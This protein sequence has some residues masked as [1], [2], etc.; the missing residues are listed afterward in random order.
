MHLLG[1]LYLMPQVTELLHNVITPV[2]YFR[3]VRELVQPGTLHGVSLILF[4]CCTLSNMYHAV[5]D[6]TYEVV[7]CSLYNACSSA[8]EAFASFVC[9][10]LLQVLQQHQ[11]IVFLAVVMYLISL[12]NATAAI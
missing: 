8:C 1:S 10:R 5:S 3:F 12:Y 4:Y 7:S 9:V 6:V 2:Y 11:D